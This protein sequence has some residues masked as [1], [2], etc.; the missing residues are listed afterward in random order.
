MM[1][2]W[3]IDLDPSTR[4]GCPHPSSEGVCPLLEGMEIH[5]PR[6]TW[7]WCLNLTC[8]VVSGTLQVDESLCESDQFPRCP[9]PSRLRLCQ[10]GESEPRS[11]CDPA[12]GTEL[13]LVSLT[14]WKLGIRPRPIGSHPPSPRFL[15][16]H[17]PELS[18]RTGCAVW[19]R[20]PKMIEFFEAPGAEEHVLLLKGPGRFE[21][22]TIT[23][24]QMQT[25]CRQVE[26]EVAR[27]CSVPW[28]E[29]WNL[30]EGKPVTLEVLAKMGG[31][32]WR[33]SETMILEVGV[34]ASLDEQLAATE[35]LPPSARLLTSTVLLQ[36]A[37]LLNELAFVL[38]QE[39]W[40][41]LT[42]QLVL[43]EVNLRLTLNDQARQIFTEVRDR[44]QT[45]RQP[46][47]EAEAELG[48]ARLSLEERDKESARAHLARAR[49]LF[50]AAKVE[51]RFCFMETLIKN[52]LTPDPP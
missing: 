23:P 40:L 14:N 43:A 42:F 7:L 47:F 51:D 25:S 4:S 8:R 24:E 45:T 17:C 21:P 2:G 13:S 9:I 26:G 39:E 27:L 36:E 10:R 29:G 22:Q 15:S 12:L 30:P 37:G 19:R 35:G 44:A 46:V 32:D 28:V 3:L 50:T 1:R 52:H 48:L 38:R 41:P 34:E 6:A 20:E 11:G 5:L 18:Y 31:E 33:E 49:T 16:P